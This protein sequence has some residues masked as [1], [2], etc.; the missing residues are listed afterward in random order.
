M[1]GIYALVTKF[2]LVIV[3]VT[4]LGVVAYGLWRLYQG[5]VGKEHQ[6]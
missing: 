6:D 3:A 2:L 5:I 1:I 4:V